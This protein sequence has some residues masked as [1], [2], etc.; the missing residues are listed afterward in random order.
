MNDPKLVNAPIAR[1][2]DCSV[3]S[4]TFRW[5]SVWSVWGDKGTPVDT[6]LRCDCQAYTWAEWQK[7]MEKWR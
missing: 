1:R 4:H 7:V 2:T 6:N 3:G 5:A